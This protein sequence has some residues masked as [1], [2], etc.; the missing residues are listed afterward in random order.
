MFIRQPIIAAANDGSILI[1]G[2]YSNDISTKSSLGVFSVHIPNNKQSTARIRTYDFS[3]ELMKK[4]VIRPGK[5]RLNKLYSFKSKFLIPR[6]NDNYIFISEQVHGQSYDGIEIGEHNDDIIIISFNKYGD[7]LWQNVI[8]KRQSRG[9][10]S[11][12][13]IS[14]KLDKEN[15]VLLYNDNIK[16]ALK[17]NGS[18]NKKKLDYKTP[19]ILF[20]ANINK[21]GHISYE[22]IYQRLKRKEAVPLVPY[23]Y[24]L[25]DGQ[26]I[27]ML[28][29]NYKFQFMKAKFEHL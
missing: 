28:N 17:H 23:S 15:I 29:E 3:D 2:F 22:V 19:S 13:C 14:A 7:L 25:L 5:E 21:F 12:I 11:S 10:H 26:I 27:F 24:Q 16:N 18:K 1:V 6:S 20:A 4:I 9:L 8:K